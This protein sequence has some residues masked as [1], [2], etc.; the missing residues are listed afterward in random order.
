MKQ[1]Y[2]SSYQSRILRT[3]LLFGLLSTT[4]YSQLSSSAYRVLGQPTLQQNG[5]NMVQGVE[6]NS[7]SG[8]ALDTRD[9]QTHLY[10]ADTRNSR[11]LAWPDVNSYLIGDSPAIILAQPGP[12]YTKSLGIGAKGLTSPYGMAVEPATGNLY[13]ADLG[14]NRVLRFLSPFKNPSFA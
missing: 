2:F 1:L 9:G 14:N 13:V 3:T 5:L 10:I 6:L 12:Q 4:S 8:L 7:P 11:I